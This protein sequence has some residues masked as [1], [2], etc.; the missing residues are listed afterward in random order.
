MALAG[1]ILGIMGSAVWTF[2]VVAGVLVYSLNGGHFATT[3]SAIPCD[4]LEH[5]AVHYHLALQIIEDGSPVSIPTN[6]GRPGG[7]YYWLHMHADRPGVIHVEAP[8]DRAFTL[9]D[10]FDVWAVSTKQPIQLD[11]RHVGAITLNAGQT[12]V[13]FVDGA[14]SDEDPRGIRLVRG[15]LIQLEVTPPL[16]DPPP[17]L[18]ISLSA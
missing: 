15:R 6:V 8:D 16:I 9:G 4:Q 13:V 11:R 12:L 18:Q 7:C 14:R 5:T 2:V 10:F 3:G 17:P 1:V